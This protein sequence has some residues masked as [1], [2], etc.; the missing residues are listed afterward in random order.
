MR[1]TVPGFQGQVSVVAPQRLQDS[2]ATEAKN[3]LIQSG[4]LIAFKTTAYAAASGISPSG[5]DTIYKHP[6]RWLAWNG[7]VNVVRAPL[8]TDSLNRIYYADGSNFRVTDQNILGGGSG[9]PANSRNIGL[10]VPALP[11][12]SFTQAGTGTVNTVTIE[13]THDASNAKLPKVSCSGDHGL[14][15][16]DSIILNV[17]GFAS[18]GPYTVV[19]TTDCATNEFRIRGFNIKMANWSSIQKQKDDTTNGPYNVVVAANSHPFNDGD[20]VVVHWGSNSTQTNNSHGTQIVADTY[21]YQVGYQDTGHFQLGGTDWSSSHSPPYKILNQ[22]HQVAVCL[23]DA[24]DPF[25][26]TNTDGSG[27]FSSLPTWAWTGT[28]FVLIASADSSTNRNTW[29]KTD[30]A[31]SLRDRVYVATFVNG[32]GEEGPPSNP[33][34]DRAMTQGTA[35][36][37]NALPT[38]SLNGPYDYNIASIRLYR[39]DINGNYRLVPKTDSSGNLVTDSSGNV[40]YDIPYSPTATFVDYATDTQLAEVIPTIGWYE[41]P[42]NLKGIIVMPGGVI[43]GFVGKTVYACYPYI[44]SAWPVEYQVNVDYPIVGLSLTAAGIIV[45]TEGFPAL[46]VGTDPASWSAVKLESYQACASAR[47]IVDMGDYALYASPFGLVAIDQNNPQVATE[48]IF[49]R[50]QWQNFIPSN[51]TGAFYEQK[52]FGSNGSMSFVFNPATKDF[53]EVDQIFSAFYSDPL[54]DTL[55]ALQSDGSIVSW[56]RGSSYLTYTWTSK[57]FQLPLPSNF[58]AAQ[59]IS[60]ASSGNPITFNLY[61]DGNL[62]T[63]VSVSSNDPFRLPSGYRCLNYQ[64]TLIG[65]ARIKMVSVATSVSE[66]KEV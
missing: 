52:Y 56:E 48:S 11:M 24:A 65:S 40:I 22:T 28:E 27:A 18:Q 17:P 15:N 43:V 30:I 20:T 7:K 34:P 36:T 21:A 53:V 41:P 59:V 12:Y 37:F 66:L 4:D 35:V 8:A 1:I 14:K 9:A 31:S 57:L 10:P 3:C 55:Y 60:E 13:Y 33:T 63:N 46:I 38:T 50:T 51:I 19:L 58:G 32:Y 62:L 25:Y 26:G 39:T 29:T 5:N 64:I 2:Q 42:S 44:P 16:N 61:G 54:T 45:L 47:S 23:Q 49:S 6:S